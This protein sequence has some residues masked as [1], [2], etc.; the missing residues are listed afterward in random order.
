MFEALMPTLV[1]DEQRHAP[2]SLGPND[3][4]HAL[5][6]QRYATG[7]LGYPVWGLSPSAV[8]D[9]SGY[10]EYGV[11]VLGTRG[12]RAG[13]VTPHAAALALA[14]EPAAATAVLRRLATDYP[15]YGEFGFYDAVDPTTGQVVQSYL[16][17]D[18]SMLFVAVA[19]HLTGGAIPRHFA[20]DPVVERVLPLL[21]AESWFDRE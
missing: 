5:V 8:P 13:A 21:G 10:R 6:Q 18:Q 19:N 4:A 15:I 1:L 11:R 9:G 12:Y 3:R 14:V 2:K 7:P 20:R 17:L 16:T